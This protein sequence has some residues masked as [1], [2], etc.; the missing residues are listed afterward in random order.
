L[1]PLVSQAPG[2]RFLF[3]QNKLS[4]FIFFLD[5][6]VLRS[7]ISSTYR[8]IP[9]CMDFCVSYSGG[10]GG[11]ADSLLDSTASELSSVRPK[12]SGGLSKFVLQ[13]RGKKNPPSRGR[14][15]RDDHCCHLSFSVLPYCCPLFLLL[16][17]ANIYTPLS[18]VVLF[19][20]SPPVP[21]PPIRELRDRVS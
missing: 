19:N 16:S 3:S 4:S 2:P 8:P 13:S 7:H 9:P 11:G 18:S 10:G 21:V 15:C 6:T 1:P 5:T 12:F 14:V 17:L 20:L